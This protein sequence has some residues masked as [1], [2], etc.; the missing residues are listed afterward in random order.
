MIYF[1]LKRS[2]QA[3]SVI[4]FIFLFSAC[5]PL[6]QSEGK[7]VIIVGS[8]DITKT[9][10]KKDIEDIKDEMGISD[11]E[12]EQ[13]IESVINKIVEKYLIMEYGKEQKIEI[14]DE[15]LSSSIKDITKD[16]PN[17]AFKDMLLRDSID[18]EAWEKNL[19]QKL[20]I[21]KITQKAIGKTDPVMIDEIQAYYNSHKESFRHPRMV[22]LRQ[23]VVQSRDEAEK[24]LARLAAGEDMGQIAQKSSI[25]PDAKNNGVVGWISKGQFDEDI[26]DIIFSLPAGK[27]SDI[28]KS[29]YGY[30]IFEVMEERDEGYS[31][32]PDVM[33]EI[34]A[35]LT[36]QKKELS[37]KK[38]ISELKNRY[39]VKI[40]EDIYK[41]WRK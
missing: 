39:P 1:S 30:H 25:T 31:S 22:R 18:Y 32:L 38:W 11:S 14:S 13:G 9:E 23:I 28:M 20:L 7:A 10:L 26:E 4:V 27:R 34:E 8:R 29:S 6:K 21:E 2:F 3:V 5:H 41:S 24:I 17:E 19:L 12:L 36:L 15:E 40:E 33:K 35:T 37:Y 16:Y